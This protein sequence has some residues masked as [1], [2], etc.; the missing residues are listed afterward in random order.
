VTG[1]E[2]CLLGYAIVR[3]TTGTEGP[4]RLGNCRAVSI[5][6]PLIRFRLQMETGGCD[7]RQWRVRGGETGANRRGRSP[8]P[9][10]RRAIRRRVR[11]GRRSS[12]LVCPVDAQPLRTARERTAR[13]ARV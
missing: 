13:R 12:P 6:A 5:K 4:L 10:R 11:R 3:A 9:S 7:Y 1:A 2:G 8:F